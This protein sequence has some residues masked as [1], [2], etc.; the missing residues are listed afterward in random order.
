M[1]EKKF[2][3][4]R[5]ELRK[6]LVSHI[7]LRMLEMDGV[8]NWS[9]YGES[10]HEAIKNFYPEDISDKEITN[11]DIDFIDC[12]EAMIDA[13]AYRELIEFEEE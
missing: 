7:T 10:R 2:V 4:T 3:L 11:N 5:G 1:S 13:G 8:D 12:A 9:W 6:L